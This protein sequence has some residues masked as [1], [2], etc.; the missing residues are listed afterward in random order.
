[1]VEDSCLY[2]AD[3]VTGRNEQVLQK[4]GPLVQGYNCT[5][6][7]EAVRPAS[8]LFGFVNQALYFF[9]Y[10]SSPLVLT[11]WSLKY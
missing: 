9:L 3:A 1:M 4:R 11:S 5:F 8:L 6:P 2:W 10:V 7:S